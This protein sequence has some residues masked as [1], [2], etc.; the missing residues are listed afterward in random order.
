MHTCMHACRYVETTG[1]N[2]PF[3][4]MESGDLASGCSI[5]TLDRRMVLRARGSSVAVYE[6]LF[7]GTSRMRNVTLCW[8]PITGTPFGS[9]VIL[10]S[11]DQRKLAS[12]AAAR[13]F[14]G[15]AFSKVLPQV[16]VYREY[17]RTLSSEIFCF[18]FPQ[19]NTGGLYHVSDQGGRPRECARCVPS[20][21]PLGPYRG[22]G[23]G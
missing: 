21:R 10:D 3:D 12:L 15:L 19:D 22:G 13:V 5:A 20:P 14:P 2:S 23:G 18:L 16:T 4:L 9:A 17:T 11:L 6:R 7:S 8:A 1:A